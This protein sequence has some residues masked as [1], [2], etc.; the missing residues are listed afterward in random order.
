[1][2]KSKILLNRFIRVKLTEVFKNIV[3][4][5]SQQREINT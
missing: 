5:S 3:L 4:K 1:M 2:A